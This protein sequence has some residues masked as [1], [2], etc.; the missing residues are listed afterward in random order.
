MPASSLPFSVP[1]HP[2]SRSCFSPERQESLPTISAPTHTSER[3]SSHHALSSIWS[4]LNHT[5]CRVQSSLYHT[6]RQRFYDH[7][8]I[9]WNAFYLKNVCVWE[10]TLEHYNLM[11]LLCFDI[12]S[13]WVTAA[14]SVCMT[15]VWDKRPPLVR[16][17]QASTE[18]RLETLSTPLPLFLHSSQF[19]PLP[20]NVAKIHSK[21]HESVN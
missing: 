10:R 8:L 19:Q 2:L 7:L 20:H 14:L 16:A 6:Q 4:C 12:D 18:H 21:P 1:I 5:S 15:S 11:F 13:C 3:H 17:E 9:H